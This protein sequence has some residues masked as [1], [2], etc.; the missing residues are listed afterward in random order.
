[1]FI[2]KEP[3]ALM[4]RGLMDLQV[5]RLCGGGEAM[6]L[7]GAGVKCMGAARRAA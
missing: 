6:A 7:V 2:L 5:H 3:E 1:M 4:A